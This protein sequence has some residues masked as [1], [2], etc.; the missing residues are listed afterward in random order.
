MRKK[1]ASKGKRRKEERRERRKEQNR[2][3][4]TRRK[5]KEKEI[6]HPEHHCKTED[7]K[8]TREKTLLLT[9]KQQ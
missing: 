5:R 9:N 6:Q 4:G 7:C 8:V 1:R 3:E 2:K